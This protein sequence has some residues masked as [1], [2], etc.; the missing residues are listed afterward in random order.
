VLPLVGTSNVDEVINP[1]SLSW[2]VMSGHP[3][4]VQ[5][6]ALDLVNVTLA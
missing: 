4:N 3:F 6:P 1:P 5:V 2:S